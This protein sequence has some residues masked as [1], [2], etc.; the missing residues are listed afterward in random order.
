MG[1]T[2]WTLFAAAVVIGSAITAIP[3][4]ARENGLTCAEKYRAAM[5]TGRLKHG[6]TKAAFMERCAA[7]AR[8]ERE[9]HGGKSRRS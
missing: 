1:A 3:V 7:E 6:V 5:A 4:L 8:S 9:R 2:R